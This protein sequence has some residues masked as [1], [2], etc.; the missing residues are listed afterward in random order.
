VRFDSAEWVDFL[1]AV[2]FLFVTKAAVPKERRGDPF[3]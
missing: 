3:P 1:K 2:D